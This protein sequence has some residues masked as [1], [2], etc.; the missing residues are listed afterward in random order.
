MSPACEKNNISTLENSVSLINL[1]S[2]CDSTYSDLLDTSSSSYSRSYRNFRSNEEYLWAMK[3]DLAEWLNNLYEININADNFIHKL[4]TGVILCRYANDVIN[5][6]LSI[7]HKFNDA[8]DSG[9]NGNDAGK[10]GGGADSNN[11][12]QAIYKGDELRY[13]ANAK[14]KTFQARDN[15]SNF[16][17]WCKSLKIHDCLLFETDD[18]VLG[19]NEK[20][21]ILCLLEVSRKCTAFGMV[22]PLIVQMEQEIDRELNSEQLIEDDQNEIE[23][24]CD[25]SEYESSLVTIST[26]PDSGYM[27]SLISSESKDNQ[28][29]ESN[30]ST[31]TINNY[32]SSNDDK[33][34]S[35]I[36]SESQIVTNNLKCLHE[37]VVDLL[38]RCTCP[39]QFPMVKVADGK[40]RVG[41]P[42]V[43]IY[44]RILRNHVMVRVGG[45]WDT[46]GHYLDRHDP[47]RCR[48]GTINKSTSPNG[49]ST[50]PIINKDKEI[51]LINNMN[52]MNNNNNNNNSP[53][54]TMNQVN[55]QQNQLK[56]SLANR[57]SINGS[58][59]WINYNR[60]PY[61]SNEP[62]YT[63]YDNLRFST[64]SMI[65]IYPNL[66]RRDSIGLTESSC[67]L[68][69]FSE[70]SDRQPSRSSQYSDDSSSST[71]SNTSSTSS[72]ATSSSTITSSMGSS[73][74][75]S[76][77]SS[78]GRLNHLTTGQL[79]SSSSI[80]SSS[81]SSSPSSSLYFNHHHNQFNR[82]NNNNNNLLIKSQPQRDQINNSKNYNKLITVNQKISSPFNHQSKIKSGIA[83]Y[84]GLTNRNQVNYQSRP[85]TNLNKVNSCTN[86]RFCHQST[87][88]TTTTSPSTGTIKQRKF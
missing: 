69:S 1:N 44:V 43:L 21:F 73:P 5:K 79:N 32:N 27:G 14:P 10:G 17:S 34:S 71:H 11:N 61:P 48:I 41:N 56:S 2:S 51:N 84:I 85:I 24:N 22:A 8:K 18:L 35:T 7:G 40:Y 81:S 47:C 82:H 59:V 28:S 76:I 20:S 23:D 15:V 12:N 4:E 50:N 38:N 75:S 72:T 33:Q 60:Q 53:T 70:G 45:G 78:T 87:T 83:K 25:G 36:K 74:R 55:H 66:I 88:T 31:T 49:L 42:K 6:A 46:L 62:Q 29:I 58:Q 37:R 68:N 64:G 77:S 67:S 63:S 54:I 26:S 52:T 39:S 80:S 30:Q 13:R 3:E 19:K 16:I 57:K 9:G 86:I 65:S